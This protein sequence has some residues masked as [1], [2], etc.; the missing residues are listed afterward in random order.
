M[1]CISVHILR[2]FF[3]LC[4]SFTSDLSES[5]TGLL[6]DI[7]LP[8]ELSLA[9]PISG[10][11]LPTHVMCISSVFSSPLPPLT[12][13]AL[14]APQDLPS[15]AHKTT[16]SAPSK[17]SFKI[18]S[19]LR[20]GVSTRPYNMPGTKSPKRIFRLHKRRFHLLACLQV[21]A[22]CGKVRSWPDPGFLHKRGAPFCS[23]LL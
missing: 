3:V 13:T 23:S 18:S 12:L 11:S 19:K 20:R 16:L 5:L 17:I 10:F 21:A 9:S 15:A 14:Q 1:G 22:T 6:S 4:I 7:K 8:L 2:F